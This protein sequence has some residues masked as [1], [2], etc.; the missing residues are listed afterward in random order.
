MM[1]FSHLDVSKVK[2]WD[3]GSKRFLWQLYKH[4]PA[5]T[6]K[7]GPETV[8]T[9]KDIEALAE[10]L[11]Q[12][13]VDAEYQQMD[14]H[15]P[16]LSTW[17]LAPEVDKAKRLSVAIKLHLQKFFEKPTVEGYLF[18]TDSVEK[19]N[20]SFWPKTMKT[21]ES[22]SNHLGGLSFKR[23]D[24]KKFYITMDLTSQQIV[25]Q[26]QASPT[27]TVGQFAIVQKE[28][29]PKDSQ[30]QITHWTDLRNATTN[31]LNIINYISNEHMEILTPLH[32]NVLNPK[33]FK[34]EPEGSPGVGWKIESTKSFVSDHVDRKQQ[35]QQHTWWS[36]TESKKNSKKTDISQGQEPSDILQG[37]S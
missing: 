18:D 31:S 37:F 15:I 22:V 29:L 20:S 21:F 36:Q 32:D 4:R 19:E 28:D 13:R 24:K 12:E 16:W 5:V 30:L 3:W 34:E 17:V 8:H 27:Q 9:L 7:C 6:K 2:A 33:C 11:S 14:G 23:M 1:V 25:S 35:Q 26:L 10:S